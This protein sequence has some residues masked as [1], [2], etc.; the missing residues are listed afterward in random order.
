[1]RRT[2]STQLHIWAV[3]GIRT[4]EKIY[5]KILMD[6]ISWLDG[7]ERCLHS[8]VWIKNAVR[9]YS[10]ITRLPDVYSGK[11]TG[12][13]LKSLASGLWSSVNFVVPWRTLIIVKLKQLR[14][15]GLVNT[16]LQ[17]AQWATKNCVTYLFKIFTFLPFQMWLLIFVYIL[18]CFWVCESNFILPV[19]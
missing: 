17:L 3:F 18:I 14:M 5:K 10:K 6:I 1:M 8:S 12:P 9:C 13:S 11:F 2:P 19:N 4:K 15:D 7:V 16:T